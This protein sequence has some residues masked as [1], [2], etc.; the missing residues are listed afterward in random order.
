MVLVIEEYAIE[1]V[2]YDRQSSMPSQIV[3]LTLVERISFL[4]K[5]FMALPS[6]SCGVRIKYAG[7]RLVNP[8]AKEPNRIS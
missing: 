7:K 4:N 1:F 8:L 5:M 6:I 2:L 3:D